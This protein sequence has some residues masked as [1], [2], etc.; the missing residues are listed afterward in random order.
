MIMMAAAE[1]LLA[2]PSS[3]LLLEGGEF[4][5]GLPAMEKP[6][7][8]HRVFM[9]KGWLPIRIISLVSMST[10]RSTELGSQPCSLQPSPP[11]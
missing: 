1:L 10:L 3:T 6:Q 11:L 2:P 5:G 9:M 4:D 8:A 7:F